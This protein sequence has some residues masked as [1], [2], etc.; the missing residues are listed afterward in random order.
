MKRIELLL[1]VFLVEF[2]DT[3]C[4]IHQHF[5]TS[6]EGVGSI[7]DLQFYKWILFAVFK[8]GCFFSL[9]CRACQECFS[10]AHVFEYN[11]PVL[12]RMDTFFHVLFFMHGFGHAF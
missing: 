8:C 11:E 1:R 3:S 9:S 10:I 4:C 2:V 6:E 5:L 7:R 12:L